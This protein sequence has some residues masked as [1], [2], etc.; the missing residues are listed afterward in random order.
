MLFYYSYYTR[1]FELNHLL[2]NICFSCVTQLFVSPQVNKIYFILFFFPVFI[3]V[4]PI[5]SSHC[6][7]LFQSI[8]TTGIH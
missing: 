6:G 5:L 8:K 2:Y 3:I 1:L 4:Y 7:I